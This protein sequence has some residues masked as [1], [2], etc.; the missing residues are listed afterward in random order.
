MSRVTTEQARKITSSNSTGYFSLKDDGN[1]AK[2]RFMYD[3]IADIE[4]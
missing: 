3:S 2:V 4:T 1:K